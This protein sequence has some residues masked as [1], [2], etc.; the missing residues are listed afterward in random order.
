MPMLFINSPRCKK[1]KKLCK[2]I[3]I[4]I[5]I[6]NVPKPIRIHPINDLVVNCSCKK[7]KAKTKVITTLSLSTGTTLDASPICKAL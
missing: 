6:S 4:Y 3:S 5:T 7:T 2:G 1:I